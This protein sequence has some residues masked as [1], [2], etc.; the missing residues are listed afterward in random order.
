VAATRAHEC[1]RQS[2][3]QLFSTA[4]IHVISFNFGIHQNML[5]GSKAWNR[6]ARTLS[7]LL[8]KVAKGCDAD[9]IFGCEMGGHREGFSHADVDL[10]YVL[11]EDLPEASYSLDGAYGV[12]YNMDA[13]VAQLRKSG[14]FTPPC[15]RDVDMHWTIFEIDFGGD[16]QPA[17]GRST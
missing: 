5:Q 12:F 7:R 9:F 2:D 1:E 8:Q 17:V 11:R 14:T 13:D 10:D 16:S 6:H 15:G 3:Q 4:I